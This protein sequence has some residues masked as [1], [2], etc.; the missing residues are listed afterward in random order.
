MRAHLLP[1]LL[2]LLSFL[3]ANPI[4]AQTADEPNEGA[5]LSRDEATGEYTVRWWG[6][7]GQTYFVQCGDDLIHWNYVPVIESGNAAVIEYGFTCTAD[8][9]FLRLR[10]TNAATGGAPDTADF[11]GDG[12]SNAA[13]IAVEGPHSDPFLADTD[14]DGFGDAVEAAVGTDAAGAG[15]NPLTL[16]LTKLAALNAAWTNYAILLQAG[17]YSQQEQAYGAA[18]SLQNQL[19]QYLAGMSQLLPAGTDPMA[20]VRETFDEMAQ[21]HPES[22]TPPDP[23]KVWIQVWQHTGWVNVTLSGVLYSDDTQATILAPDPDLTEELRRIVYDDGYRLGPP[24]RQVD[25]A[26]KL[27]NFGQG[28]DWVTGRLIAEAARAGTAAGPDPSFEIEW[29]AEDVASAMPYG[30][31]ATNAH[32]AGFGDADGYWKWQ[33]ALKIRV[34][35]AIGTPR[36]FSFLVVRYHGA[37]MPRDATTPPVVM[38]TVTF[39]IPKESTTVTV[40]KSAGVPGSWVHVRADGCVVVGN[41]TSQLWDVR[42]DPDIQAEGYYL[43]P[44]E[45]LTPKLD[46]EG[47]DTGAW[48]PASSLRV[49]KMEDSLDA[50][51]TL[52]IDLDPDRFRFLLPGLEWAQTVSIKLATEDNPKAAYNDDETE[53]ELERTGGG[54]ETSIRWRSK[55]LLLVSDDEDDL[56]G[57]GEDGTNYGLDDELNDRTHKVQLGGKVKL[58]AVK[59]DGREC[60]TAVKTPVPVLAKMPIQIYLMG[61]SGVASATDD[62]DVANERLAQVGVQVEAF[63]MN[64]GRHMEPG[65]TSLVYNSYLSLMGFVQFYGTA[66]DTSDVQVFFVGE[67]LNPNGLRLWGLSQYESAH[68][69]VPLVGYTNTAWI[70]PIRGPF[71]LAHELGHLL[72]RLNHYGAGERWDDFPFTAPAHKVRHNLMRRGGS[73]TNSYTEGKRIFNVQLGYSNL[74]KAP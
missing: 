1:L 11:D 2:F 19:A 37:M 58:A 16:G 23:G 33:D 63:P 28:A 6:R 39:K 5:R 46:A 34:E 26:T 21:S 14:G 67:I 65:S 45:I 7:S 52:H 13:E 59:T 62:L 41:Y 31:V 20:P 56:L 4:Q 42:G 24:E 57:D 10:Y 54:P 47:H 49:A 60:P 30:L 66:N 35:K 17:S 71:T 29:G 3:S 55:S 53:L 36:E 12:L 27:T 51:D 73:P 61:D 69:G 74:L 8:R 18:L 38:G 25:D 70:D 22:Q 72:T 15:D 68:P 64:Q 44:V 32:T 48:A 50:N 40:E 43:T 9:F